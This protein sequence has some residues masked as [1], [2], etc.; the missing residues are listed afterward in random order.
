MALT[1]QEADNLRKMLLEIDRLSKALRQN[2]NT[3]N[4]QDLEKSADNIKF[5]FEKLNKEFKEQNDEISYA[6][7]GFK[8]IVQEISNANVGLRESN[9]VYNNLSSLASQIQSHQQGISELSSKELANKKK[10]AE[11]ARLELGNAQELLRDKEKEQELELENL[12]NLKK[13]KEKHLER[14]KN[15]HASQSLIEKYQKTI[16][17]VSEKEEKQGELL[18]KTQGLLKENASILEN[19]NELY[20]GLILAIDDETRKAKN[21]EKA[22]GLSGAAVEGIGKALN[23]AG[24]G[25]LAD[26]MGLDDAKEKMK[27]VAHQVTKGG[28]KSAGLVGQFKILKAGIGSLG[29]SIMKNLTDPLVMAGLAAKAVSAGVGGIKKGFSLLKGGVSSVVGFVKNLWGMADQFAAVF[30]KYAKAGQFA[31]QNFSMAGGQVDKVASGLK[32]AAAADPFMRVSEAGPALKTLVDGTGMFNDAMLKSVKEAH[33]LSYWLGYSAEETGQLYALGTL[34][35]KTSKEA[36]TTIRASAAVLNQQKNTALDQR[37]IDQAALKASNSIKMNLKNNLESLGRAAYYAVKLGMSL[38]E[39]KSSAEQTLNFEQ[40]IQDQLAYQA[41]SGKEL[42]VDA[43]QRAALSGDIEGQARELDKLIKQHGPG[44]RNNTLLQK[45]FAAAAGISVEQLGTAIQMEDLAR[46]IGADKNKTTEKYNKLLSQG[47]SAQKAM[48]ILQNEGIKGAEKYSKKAEAMSRALED[49]RDFMA[50]RLWPLFK[51]VFSPANIKMFMTA[52]NGM[53][54]VF[55]ELGKAITAF[56]SPDSAGAMSDV[57]KNDIMPAILDL[58]KML[59]EVAGGAGRTLF[60]LIK[61]LGPVIK[62]DVIP[63]VKYLGSIIQEIAPTIGTVVKALAG[64]VAGV[65]KKIN[66]NKESIKSFIE[67]LAKGMTN[68]FGFVTEHLKEIAITFVAFKALTAARSLKSAVLGAPGG[69]RMNAM[70][71]RSAD[72]IPGGGKGEGGL[73]SKLKDLFKGGG[74]KAAGAAGATAGATSG[75]TGATSFADKRK[76]VLARQAAGEGLGSKASSVTAGAKGAAGAASGAV[77]VPEGADKAGG[78]LSKFGSTM[79]KAAGGLLKA[80]AALVLIA[81]SLYIAAKAF[82]EF[83]LVDWEDIG[84]GTVALLALGGAVFALSK[85]LGKG[86]VLVA[87]AAMVIMAGSLW[88]M[89]DAMNK[90]ATVKAEDL[91]IAAGALVLLTGAVLGLGA[92][93]ASGI[94]A[95][96]FLAGVAA[97]VAMG[98]AL[99]VV[100]GGL[101]A[102]VKVAGGGKL[103][104]LGVELNKGITSLTTNLADADF[105]K[106]EDIFEGIEDAFD[107]LDIDELLAFSE[108]A[109]A[110]LAG[111]AQNLVTGIQKLA[112]LDLEGEALD[113]SMITGFSS[114]LAEYFDQLEDVFDEVEDAIDELDIDALLQ[115]SELANVS[116]VGAVRNLA[117]GMSEMEKIKINGKSNEAV[118]ASL[119]SIE[120]IADEFEDVLGEL[121]FSQLTEFGQI[122]KVGLVSAVTT[123]KLGIDEFTKHLGGL[124]IDGDKLDATRKSFHK[125]A[126]VFGSLGIDNIVKFA[127]LSKSGLEEAATKLKTAI[128]TLGNMTF[129]ISEENTEKIKTAFRTLSTSFT[130]SGLDNII[131]FAEL[132][133]GNLVGAGDN[134]KAGIEHFAKLSINV[135]SEQLQPVVTSFQAFDNAIGSLQMENILKFAEL[136]KSNLVNAATNFKNGVDA[137]NTVASTV[138]EGDYNNIV[139]LKEPIEKLSEAFQGDSKVF[140]NLSNFAKMELGDIKAKIGKFKEALD[141]LNALGGSYDFGDANGAKNPFENLQNVF[142]ELNIAFGSDMSGITSFLGTNFSDLD[143]SVDGFIKG[144]KKLSSTDEKTGLGKM[145]LTSFKQLLTDLNTS[146]AGLDLTSFEKFAELK[147]DK[148]PASMTSLK[149]GMD[150]INKVTINKVISDLITLLPQ[151]HTQLTNIANFDPAKFVS[152]AGAIITLSDSFKI[153]AETITSMG[154][155]TPIVKVSDQMLKLHESVSKNP[156]DADKLAKGVGAIFSG[157]MGSLVAFVEGGGQG[158]S[159]SFFKGAGGKVVDDAI[160]GPGEI[161]SLVDKEGN[162]V[163]IN[164]NDNVVLSTNKPEIMSAPISQPSSLNITNQTASSTGNYDALFAKIEQF[165]S[166]AEANKDKPIV[167]ENNTTLT[168]DGK[169]VAKDVFRRAKQNNISI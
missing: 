5:I 46:E 163:G 72:G 122:A 27:E 23:K 17:A 145:D 92:A 158:V 42:N 80:S 40:S 140:E 67:T 120:L 45:Q 41:M 83:A 138:K 66:E 56:F 144:V 136:A 74:V 25:S 73:L 36:L 169:E 142:T 34:N 149:K 113:K 152:L 8:R 20:N 54:P 110:N 137:L 31:A 32:A 123:L 3:T 109:G 24:L 108:L 131:K 81:G 111:A 106:L 64:G 91:G 93:M 118:I 99:Y 156:M 119:A 38:D 9:K 75:I 87:S 141:E 22:L 29:G 164:K 50:T 134:L 94:G 151:L 147:L 4:L 33:D 103:E 30:E 78:K 95:G 133:K 71:I 63:I 127:G 47:V 116:I 153:L 97:L 39:I 6:A 26:Q 130:A 86:D 65:L 44:L 61:S 105:G 166:A 117:R 124:V 159:D 160:F 146:F 14:L 37:K 55:V 70:W 2:V 89:A 84:K 28:T 52:I 101:D 1:P 107:E 115:F 128:E 162:F 85:L 155:V 58:A 48:E 82:Q 43:L 76:M 114:K 62:Q 12:E 77:P 10:K 51:A 13:A 154:D 126:Q 90:F 98:G 16:D 49:F 129:D 21:L 125:L 168:L 96:I 68:L 88:I 19:Q 100:A 143:K 132:S 148:F 59:T 7:V 11:L 60:A 79:G 167:I 112:T 157:L 18:R 15:Q 135:T 57:L 35:G 69:S 53:R 161:T 139:N 121:D 165:I 102:L 150:N 104:T